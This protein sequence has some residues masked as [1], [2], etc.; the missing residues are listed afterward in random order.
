VEEFGTGVI[1]W[2]W[3]TKIPNSNTMVPKIPKF[4]QQLHG[5]TYTLLVFKGGSRL[6]WIILEKISFA[7]EILL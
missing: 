4:C 7:E 6:D 2:W 1:F 3:G 5:I